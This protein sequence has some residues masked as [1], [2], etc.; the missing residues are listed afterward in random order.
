MFSIAF[1]ALRG[2]D[3]LVQIE[4]ELVDKEVVEIGRGMRN[5][6]ICYFQS[7][8]AEYPVISDKGIITFIDDTKYLKIIALA[9]NTAPSPRFL[10][11][12]L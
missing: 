4:T 8:I 7:A 1:N 12:T 9:N 11:S 10:S 3:E 6:T 5:T 2:P